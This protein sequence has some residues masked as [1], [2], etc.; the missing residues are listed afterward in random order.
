VNPAYF[1]SWFPFPDNSELD[2]DALGDCDYL[3]V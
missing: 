2:W 3:Y 1:A